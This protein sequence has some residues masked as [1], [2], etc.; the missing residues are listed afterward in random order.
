MCK[1]CLTL[2]YPRIHSRKLVGEVIHDE[3]RKK[4][5]QE[6]KVA[7]D[8]NVQLTTAPPLSSA[9]NSTVPPSSHSPTTVSN[10][11][12]DVI[13]DPVDVSSAR[14]CLFNTSSTSTRPHSNSALVVVSVSF[15]DALNRGMINSLR[16]AFEEEKLRTEEIKKLNKFLIEDRKCIEENPGN[17]AC[18][19]Y[20]IAGYT[21][22]LTGIDVRD[23]VTAAL[24][25]GRE[26]YEPLIRQIKSSTDGVYDP[27]TTFEAYVDNMSHPNTYGGQVELRVAMDEIK[28]HARIYTSSGVYLLHSLLPDSATFPT[29]DL[30]HTEYPQHWT[31]VKKDRKRDYDDDDDYQVDNNTIETHQYMEVDNFGS[32]EPSMEVDNVCVTEPIVTA[33]VL[34][35]PPQQVSYCS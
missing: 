28:F 2:K 34:N 18:L 33:T 23:K 5:R 1:K 13:Q 29:F 11:N 24:L 4:I 30:A 15:D 32:S 22:D 14:S 26:T 3:Q 21:L 31:A 8:A 7:K 10:N 25:N 20:S 16:S 35:E 17:G 9:V 27:T 19:F 12:T 6:R